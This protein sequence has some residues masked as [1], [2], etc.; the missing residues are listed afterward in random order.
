MISRI[1]EKRLRELAQK[2]PIVTILG[3]R[4]VGKTTLA[5]AAFPNHEYVNLES[6]RNREFAAEDHVGFLN[7]YSSGVSI[8][9]VQKAPDLSIGNSGLHR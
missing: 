8:D 6:L 3:P 4:Q 7:Q 5:W 2:I 1:L 9:E